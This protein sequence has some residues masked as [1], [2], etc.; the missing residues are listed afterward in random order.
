MHLS[1]F[2]SNKPQSM[3]NEDW[4]FKYL[5]ICGYIKQ[6]IKDNI[7]NAIMNETNSRS[8]WN[9]FE[10]FYTLKIEN[11]VVPIETVGKYYIEREIFYF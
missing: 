8:L 3:T 1:V 7:R 6:W 2:T 9:K 10:I 4:K 5:H 11:I